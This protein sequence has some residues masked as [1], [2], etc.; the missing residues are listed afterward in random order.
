[1]AY[2]AMPPCHLPA[3]L[4]SCGPEPRPPEP[5]ARKGRCKGT[6]P[7]PWGAGLRVSYH[8]NTSVKPAPPLSLPPLPHPASGTT[9]MLLHAPFDPSHTQQVPEGL[10]RGSR[11]HSGLQGTGDR[12]MQK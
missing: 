6:N 2:V 5:A 3:P 10:Q 4:E 11:G 9:T 1:M 8:L 12:R 7:L